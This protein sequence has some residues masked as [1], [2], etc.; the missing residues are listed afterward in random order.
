MMARVIVR[1]QAELDVDEIAA[2]IAENNLDAAL[3]FLRAVENAYELLAA[4]PRIGTR[5]IARNPSLCGLR[6]Y[7]IRRFR[8]YLIFYLPFEDGVE[9][10]RVIHGA[11]DLPVVLRRS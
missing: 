1:A 7:P 2:R 9:I 4:W 11:R 5:R 8:N 3:R 10:V 6:S